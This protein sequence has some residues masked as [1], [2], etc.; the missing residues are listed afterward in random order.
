[1]VLAVQKYLAKPAMITPKSKHLS[2]LEKPLHVAVCKRNQ[3]SYLH[4]YEIGYTGNSNFFSGNTTNE[5]VLSF[6][7]MHGNMTFNE[8][9]NHVYTP[10]LENIEF[11]STKGNIS[12]RLLYPLGLCKVYEG[13][14][15]KPYFNITFKNHEQMPDYN[16]F[17]SDP[18]AENSFQLPFILMTG[19]KVRVADSIEK[20]YFVYNIQLKEIIVKTNDGSCVDYPTQQ[21][22][23]Y[24]DCVGAELK[25]KIL[26]TLGCMVPFISRKD[27]CTEPIQRLP[28][29]DN[30]TE[31]LYKISADSYGGIQYQ[32]ESC[33][34]PCSHLSSH[35]TFI[36]S[37]VN[38]RLKD[39]Q[40]LIVFGDDIENEEIVLAYDSTALLVEIGSCLGLWLGLSVVGMYDMIELALSRTWKLFKSASASFA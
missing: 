35:S 32:A 2:T 26:P 34:L 7:G 36:E 3:F 17:I 27:H 39:S 5:S 37:I 23:S 29:H 21:H 33:P 38:L 6:T 20:K 8:S 13:A 1:M 18:A 22:N 19:E 9:L 30:L 4:G 12:N 24:A 14:P 10:Y 16:I 40:L 15:T 25:R 11:V 31:A 28:K